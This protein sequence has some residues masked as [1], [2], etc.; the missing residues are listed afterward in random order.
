M[1]DSDD[2]AEEAVRAKAKSTSRTRAK[3]TREVE[4]ED[5][6]ALVSSEDDDDEKRERVLDE[7]VGA[8]KRVTLDPRYRPVITEVGRE[9]PMA[10]P[11]RLRE[12]EE[13]LTLK[14]VMAS[15]GEDALDRDTVKRLNKI[16][17]TK[18]V[19]AP[20]AR[21][22]KER[23]DRKAAYAETSKDIG[24]YQAVVKE[25]REKRTLK[26]EPARKEMQ[27]KDTLGALAA[28]FT[29]RSEVELEIARVLK[30][31]GHASAKDVVRGEL[32]E[33]DHLDV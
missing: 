14:D 4:E 15:L 23:I 31:S 33:M 6:E 3:P 5:V 1:M 21:P 32:L 29:P 16:S 2:E 22:I 13:K 18:A 17:K 28:D 19:D 30:E 7:L 20:L 25:N 27:R 24:K 10:V 12:G 8:R 26:F 9:N 11:L